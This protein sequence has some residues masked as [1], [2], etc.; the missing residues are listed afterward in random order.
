MVF[1]SKWKFVLRVAHIDIFDCE[2]IR[3]HYLT[4]AF[5]YVTQQADRKLLAMLVTAQL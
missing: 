4:L 5:A 2:Y 3:R 1:M